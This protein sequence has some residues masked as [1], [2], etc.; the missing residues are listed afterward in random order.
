MLTNLDRN[1]LGEARKSTAHLELSVLASA[2]H[3]N[4]L[5]W[6]GVV[7]QWIRAHEQSLLVDHLLDSAVGEEAREQVLEAVSSSTAN[8]F[9]VSL[10]IPWTRDELRARRIDPENWLYTIDQARANIEKVLEE[11]ADARRN[12]PRAWIVEYLKRVKQGYVE[13]LEMEYPEPASG[14]SLARGSWSSEGMA[15]IDDATR[16]GLIEIIG[17]ATVGLFLLIRLAYI[18]V[19]SREP[20]S[21][22]FVTIWQELHPPNSRGRGP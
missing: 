7:D 3:D 19:S 20:R 1:G 15:P 8:E 11:L 6:Y 21:P 16:E 18:T 5:K 10:G 13:G 12:T 14:R 2:S 4:L 17:N 22:A 9:A